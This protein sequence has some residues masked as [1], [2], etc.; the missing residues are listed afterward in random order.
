MYFASF[1]R[2]TLNRLRN[3]RETNCVIVGFVVPAAV[4]ESDDY[5]FPPLANIRTGQIYWPLAS[6]TLAR[7]M[8]QTLKTEIL[9]STTCYPSRVDSSAGSLLAGRGV[10]GCMDGDCKTRGVRCADVSELWS[11][12]DSFNSCVTCSIHD[13]WLR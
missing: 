5:L 6:P 3:R 1:V 9:S 10:A 4:Y 12:I 11:A 8:R 13:S 7:Q 2:T